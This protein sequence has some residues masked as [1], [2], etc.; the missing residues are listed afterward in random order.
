M[1]PSGHWLC[2]CRRDCHQVASGCVCL[3]APGPLAK[4]CVP[5]SHSL[6]SGDSLGVDVA[7]ER[8]VWDLPG[9]EGAC[10][11]AELHVYG[12]WASSRFHEES[13]TS[14]FPLSA[15]FPVL[16]VAGL[17]SGLEKPVSAAERP[18]SPLVEPLWTPINF[19]LPKTPGN[20]VYCAGGSATTHSPAL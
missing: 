10:G 8:R 17:G 12:G 11:S 2:V 5:S 20:G 4:G 7:T 18:D 14:Q 3:R 19:Q 15:S 1:V 13:L 6:S 16:K 9:L